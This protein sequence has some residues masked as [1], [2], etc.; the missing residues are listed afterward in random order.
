MKALRWKVMI[1]FIAGVFGCEAS[2][3]YPPA[4]APRPMV[5]GDRGMIELGQ[6]IYTGKANLSAVDANGDKQRER[7]TALQAKLPPSQRRL[8]SLPALAGHLTSE[9]L[10]ALEAFLE[11]RFEIKL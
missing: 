7:L 9:Q 5:R 1:L 11:A 6:A 2:G 8:A 4:G 10:T 3:T